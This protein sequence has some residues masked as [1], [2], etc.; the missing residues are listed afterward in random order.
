VEWVRVCGG[1]SAEVHGPRRCG[2]W[3]DLGNFLL[4]VG[5]NMMTGGVSQML[6]G[7]QIGGGSI[8]GTLGGCG[9]PLGNCG[10][11]G[12]GPW[13]EGTGLG[14]VRDPGGFHF[15]ASP[16]NTLKGPAEQQPLLSCLT[17]Y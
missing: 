17:R 16:T 15:S 13:S 7:V 5:W 9:G 11:L 3:S 6:G 10:T 8:G 14:N 1:K 2:F 12:S 4:N